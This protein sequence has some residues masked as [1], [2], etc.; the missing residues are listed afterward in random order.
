[1]AKR[2]KQKTTNVRL[3]AENYRS[4]VIALHVFAYI[5]MQKNSSA[6][7]SIGRKMTTSEYNHISQNEDQT[8]DLVVQIMSEEGYVCEAKSTLPNDS[9]WWDKHIKQLLKYDDDLLGWWTDGSKLNNDSN[10]ILLISSEKS[11]KFR[12]R[13]EEYIKEKSIVLRKPTA[14]IG[15]MRAGTLEESLLFQLDWGRVYNEELHN[16]LE[17][18]KLI[19]FERFMQ[20]YGHLK[21]YDSPPPV[22]YMMEVLWSH[23]FNDLK[24]SVKY[25]EKT[26]SWPFNIDISDITM[27]VQKLYGQ[28]TN[29][30]RETSFPKIKWVRE[31][32]EHYEAIGLAKEITNDQYIIH[33]KNLRGDLMEKFSKARKKVEEKR[34]KARQGELFP[35]R[36]K[37]HRKSM[38]K[39]KKKIRK[40]EK[41]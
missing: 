37:K 6:K 32:I 14:F 23:L 39:G 13:F 21:F 17:D 26:K 10:T 33:Y 20:S 3:E 16:S 18:R 25:D 24:S 41:S 38:R 11:V 1:M 19:P 40:N 8:P 35:K 7:Y 15:F 5:L 4:T 22:E 28:H 30:E 9:E 27:Q 2:K 31:A 29:N 36:S 12:R 34:E